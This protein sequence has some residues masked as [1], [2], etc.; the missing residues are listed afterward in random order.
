MLADVLILWVEPGDHMAGN[1]ENVRDKLLKDMKR[2]KGVRFNASK[3]LEETERKTTRNTAY[4]SV[5]VV[6]I[7][8]LPIFFSMG[9]I[10][11][12]SIALLTVALSIFILAS[13]LLQSSNSGQVKADQF[14][15]CALEVNS[16]R[17]ELGSAPETADIAGFAARY[18]EI[19][20]RYNINHDQVDYDQYRLEHPDEF[21][22][23][24]AEETKV[25]RSNLSKEWRRYDFV[26]RAIATMTVAVL[27]ATTS[28]AMKAAIET[29]RAWLKA[30]P[31][32]H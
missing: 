17:R 8:L 7:T 3:R 21:P 10:L 23:L 22:A 9:Q 4:A 12:N 24:A 5:A 29:V 11:E 6:V 2:T 28:P 19:L 31:S 13:S 32:I 26:A 16:L 30:V 18:D 20:R 14:Q 15:R 27:I 1:A 25:A